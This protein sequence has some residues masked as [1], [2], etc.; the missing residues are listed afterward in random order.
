MCIRDSF[1]NSFNFSFLGADASLQSRYVGEQYMNNARSEEARLDSYFV[2]DLHLG[3]TFRHLH[4][5]RELRIGL[6][7]YNLFNEKYFSNGYAGAGYS[8]VD[9]EKV[10]YRYAGYA[11]QAP[12]HVMATATLRF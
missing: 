1:S 5:I 9:G 3:Y 11:A 8:V 2:T 10:I 4:G 7:V 6:S 12:T